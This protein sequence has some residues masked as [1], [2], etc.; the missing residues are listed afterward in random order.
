MSIHIS[1]A[2]ADYVD[3]EKKIQVT[4]T[5][6]G[7]MGMA[8]AGLAAWTGI[9]MDNQS[10]AGYERTTIIDGSKAFEKYTNATETAELSIIRDNRFIIT[11]HG[12]KV[13]MDD[14][15]KAAKSIDLEV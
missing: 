14:M 10:D 2:Q 8:L 7:G 13:S 4:I 5:D 12:N 9:D 6:T 11:L 15:H 1:S 3:G